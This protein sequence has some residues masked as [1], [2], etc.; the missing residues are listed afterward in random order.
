MTKFSSVPKSLNKRHSIYPALYRQYLLLMSNT[1]V[2]LGAL[3]II[4]TNSVL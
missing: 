1:E 2:C 3:S 4:K